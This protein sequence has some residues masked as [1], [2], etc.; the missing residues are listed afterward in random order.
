MFSFS[1]DKLFV[2]GIIALIVLGPNRL[3][4]AARTVGRFVATF[5]HVTSGFQA[6]VREALAEPKAAFN[7]AIN[8]FEAH[9]FETP[10][11]QVPPEPMVRRAPAARQRN[12]DSEPDDHTAGQSTSSDPCTGEDGAIG[13]EVSIV[14]GMS[15]NGASVSFN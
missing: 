10:T 15:S 6:E 2:V 8:D 13:S 7:A 1:P 11:D 14:H 3:P 5:R 4:E 12:P 9:S